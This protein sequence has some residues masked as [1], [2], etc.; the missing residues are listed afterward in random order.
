MS[1]AAGTGNPHHQKPFEEWIRHSEFLGLLKIMVIKQMILKFFV[2]VIFKIV[3]L[4][5]CVTVK[6]SPNVIRLLFSHI[7]HFLDGRVWRVAGPIEAF[8]DA[9]VNQRMT[10]TQNARTSDS[11]CA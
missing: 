3:A 9:I 1:S 2:T 11:G 10:K 5:A 6:A 4:C 8:V 7:F